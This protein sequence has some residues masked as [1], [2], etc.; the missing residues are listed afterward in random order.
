ME[1]KIWKAI[2]DFKM[3]ENATSI[4]VGVSGGIDSVSLLHFL[5]KNFKEKKI[6]VA[7]VNHNLRGDESKRDENF[8]KNLCEKFGVKFFLKSVNVYHFAKKK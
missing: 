6:I 8:V 2:K 7:H 3:F 5:T 4:V 1:K